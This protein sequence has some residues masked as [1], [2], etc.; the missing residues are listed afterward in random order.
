MP[1]QTPRHLL[2]IRTRAQRGFSLF[3][4]LIAVLVLSFGLL[5]MVS[6]QTIAIKA[7]RDAQQHSTASQYGRELAEI[8]KTTTTSLIQDNADGGSYFLTFDSAMDDLRTSI[9]RGI[10]CWDAVCNSPSDWTKW[11]MSDWLYRVNADLPGAKVVVCFDA[12]SYDTF[13]LPQW[14]C[15]N[16]GNVAAIKLGWTR[17]AFSGQA[18]G[19]AAFDRATV[20]AIVVPVYLSN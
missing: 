1:M 10:N 18:Q 5:G 17:A 8:M 16:S 2:Q 20:P 15:T 6:L 4:I 11:Q 14:R 3:E 7:S 9:P 12:L 13:G 19:A